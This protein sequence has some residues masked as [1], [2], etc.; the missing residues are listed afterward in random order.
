MAY[1]LRK[2]ETFRKWCLL[3]YKEIKT[4]ELFMVIKN[5]DENSNKISTNVVKAIDDIIVL[6]KYL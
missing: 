5:L 3:Y 6:C 2:I 4:C 1:Q